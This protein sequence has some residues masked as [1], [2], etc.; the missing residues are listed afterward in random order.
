MEV[1]LASGVV[2]LRP[3]RPLINSSNSFDLNMDDS[4]ALHKFR[5]T[6]PQLQLIAVKLNMPEIVITPSNDHIIAI[7]ALAMVCRRLGECCRLFT[8]ANEFERSMEACRRTI[9]TTIQLIYASWKDVQT[10]LFEKKQ[11]TQT[12]SERNLN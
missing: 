8:I 7:E 3:E 5:F 4:T 1:M 6:I 11:Y 10:S 2:R 9:T 12:L